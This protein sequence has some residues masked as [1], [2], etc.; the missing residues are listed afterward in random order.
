VVHVAPDSA[1]EGTELRAWAERKLRAFVPEA[2]GE[3]G[4]TVTA[5]VLCGAPHVEIVRCSET[6]GADLI[7]VGRHGRRVI[8]D[9]FIGSTAARVVRRSSAPVL[10]VN[11]PAARPYDDVL[12]AVDLTDASHVAL[13]LALRVLD[14]P[15]ATVRVV[16]AFDVPAERQLDLQVGLRE[17][18]EY[19]K[20]FRRAAQAG[21][22]DLLGRYRG[23]PA[24]LESAVRAGDP[25]LVI[26]REA[27]RRRSDLVVVGTHARSGVS[28]YLLGSVAE[29][30]VEAA[31]CDVLVARPNPRALGPT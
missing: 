6:M 31:R 4:P 12:V 15:V 11:T 9:M 13:D 8:R 21:L 10:L 29:W 5:E 7:V 25:R 2:D 26:L 28:R 18:A 16:H 22:R 17:H 3:P 23:A 1:R 20:Q 24:R 19:R 30:V 14:D 27:K